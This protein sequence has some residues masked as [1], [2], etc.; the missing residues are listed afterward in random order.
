[1]N[2]IKKDRQRR[3]GAVILDLRDEPF[4][5]A[6]FAGQLFQRNILLRPF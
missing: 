6:S 2:D 4:A 3:Y 1:M 5:D